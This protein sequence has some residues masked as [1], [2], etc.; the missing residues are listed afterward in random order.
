MHRCNH[1]HLVGPHKTRGRRV[2]DFIRCVN[3]GLSTNN[4][5]FETCE[6]SKSPG[7]RLCQNCFARIPVDMDKDCISWV[8]HLNPKSM[9]QVCNTNTDMYLICELCNRYI[10]VK[11]CIPE[12]YELWGHTGADC[13][14]CLSC[15]PPAARI[16]P[17]NTQNFCLMCVTEHVGEKE[18]WPCMQGTLEEIPLL[19]AI[20]EGKD[21][22]TN[23]ETEPSSEEMLVTQT[24][25]DPE[26]GND[27][28]N[29]KRSSSKD[30]IYQSVL[31][32]QDVESPTGSILN[33]PRSSFRVISPAPQNENAVLNY[34]LKSSCDRAVNASFVCNPGLI[35]RSQE[36]MVLNSSLKSSCNR[37]TNVSFV[38]NP[39]LDNNRQE[40][41][42]Y[43]VKTGP[44]SFNHP[45]NSA[46]N[47]STSNAAFYNLEKKIENLVN[48]AML[49]L[50]N[51]ACK[52][53]ANLEAL[54]AKLDR[55]SPNKPNIAE[56]PK[57]PFIEKG[58]QW[59]YDD[60][61]EFGQLI[62]D[63]QKI[64]VGTMRKLLNNQA[65]FFASRLAN[66]SVNDR[67]FDDQSSISEYDNQSTSSHLINS[68]RPK[69]RFI[70]NDQA[71]IPL[72][73]VA[74]KSLV[75]PL[76]SSFGSFLLEQNN[77]QGQTNSN[78]GN[79]RSWNHNNRMKKNNQRNNNTRNNNNNRNSNSSN[80]NNGN[81][82]NKNQS[83]NNQRG[84][85]NSSGNNNNKK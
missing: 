51:A 15:C 35:N 20:R 82:K 47:K 44:S 33:S 42:I 2:P 63:S 85:G 23:P 30:R 59:N 45:E 5:Q 68:N 64:D 43:D 37:P 32:G 57:S 58:I 66:L 62:E 76:L 7:G 34:S 77:A 75:S 74:L 83:N 60:Q 38:S 8:E 4:K 13:I 54:K 49:P 73:R 1:H 9:C 46:I 79:Y 28:T 69:D 18:F 36:N 16:T 67:D 48:S 50:A 24:L 11:C 55:L 78:T 29:G 14:L 70:E 81:R 19:K 27:S 17:R 61:E 3:C 80:N 25:Y 26:T 6:K 53:S 84:N 39:G 12:S 22:T 40:S 52:N 31:F 10:C 41:Q 65:D 72:Q 71:L 21:F 56:E